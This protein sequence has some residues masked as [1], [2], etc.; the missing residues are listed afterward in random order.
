MSDW[1]KE[2][3]EEAQILVE[4][5]DLFQKSN[6]I[7]QQ[8]LLDQIKRLEEMVALLKQENEELKKEISLLKAKALY[9]IIKVN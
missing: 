7:C 1:H 5:H 6:D 2:L 8:L 3:L 4:K 9:D